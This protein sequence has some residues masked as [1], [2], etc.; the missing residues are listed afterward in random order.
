MPSL[1]RIARPALV[2][3]VIAI[4]LTLGVGTLAARGV[5]DEAPEGVVN[6]TR[7]DA[8][9]ACAG[10]TPAEA[11]PALQRLGFASVINFRTAEEEGANIEASQAAAAEAG[12]KY[13]H[14]PF[15]RPDADVTGQF[16]EAIADTANQ[17]AYIHCASANRVGA[18]WFI[19]RVKQD[20]WEA[21]RAMAEA[22]TI[23]LRSQPLKDFATAYVAETR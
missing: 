11:M 17:P 23:G 3:G 1:H 10:A 21:D 16:L 18:M 9:V 2:T 6:Y 5:Q 22:E 7:I 4:G 12:L 13:I 19:K 15:R 8:T 20:G 14:I